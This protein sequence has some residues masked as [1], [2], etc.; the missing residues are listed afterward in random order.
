MT[1]EELTLEVIARL[2]KE[3]PAGCLHAGLQRRLETVSQRPLGSPVY[4]RQSERS[5]KG[6][7]REIPGCGRVSQCAGGGDRGHCKA[8]RP[9]AEQGQGHQRMYENAERS[10]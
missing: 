9:G 4:G 10:V 5:G 2:K 3:Y 1:K 6:S 8:L 7:V